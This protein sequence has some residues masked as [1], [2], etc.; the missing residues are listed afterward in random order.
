MPQIGHVP[1]S[2]RTISGC[3]GQVYMASLKLA[4]SAI[5][6]DVGARFIVGYRLSPSSLSLPRRLVGYLHG[7]IS[8]VR[9][10][11]ANMRKECWSLLCVAIE[12]CAEL[13]TGISLLATR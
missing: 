7:P 4:P 10:R 2:L 9:S 6:W 1:G 12:C 5:A 3:M 13:R 8:S 11:L